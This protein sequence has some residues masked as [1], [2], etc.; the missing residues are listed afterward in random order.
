[1]F[2]NGQL[3]STALYIEKE[4]SLCMHHLELIID[5]PENASICLFTVRYELLQ[6]ILS[7]SK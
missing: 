2:T 1:M 6:Q 4:Y 3:V 5:P 7:Q